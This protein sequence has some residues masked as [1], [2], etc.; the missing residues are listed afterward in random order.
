MIVEL[1]GREANI[2]FLT[3]LGGDVIEPDANGNV[4]PDAQIAIAKFANG[5][6]LYLMLDED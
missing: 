4:G 2:V 5:E 6:V 3:E 1:A